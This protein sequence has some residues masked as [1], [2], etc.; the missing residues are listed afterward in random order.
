M[1]R[2]KTPEHKTL[3]S[4]N[5]RNTTVKFL[6]FDKATVFALSYE[7]APTFTKCS[8]I[9]L[10]P[11]NKNFLLLFPQNLDDTVHCKSLQN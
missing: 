9:I 10:S 2:R 7:K 1:P 8:G 6:F 3:T 5:T 11:T 4:V